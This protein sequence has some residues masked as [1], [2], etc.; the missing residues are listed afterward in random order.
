M[1]SSFTTLGSTGMVKA[2]A[3]KYRNAENIG[4]LS[5]SQV[6]EPVTGVG[7]GEREKK[8]HKKE[9]EKKHGGRVDR[10]LRCMLLC[11]SSPRDAVL[12]RQTQQ[13]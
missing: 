3:R 7:M 2:I 11:S 4:H 6:G 8:K 1:T 9:K 12:G 13:S 5:A 10:S